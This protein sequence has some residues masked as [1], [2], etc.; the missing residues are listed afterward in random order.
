MDFI[1]E[2]SRGFNEKSNMLVGICVTRIIM[3]PK[4]L[5]R[6]LIPR[7]SW[8]GFIWG[9]LRQRR[10]LLSRQRL[11][12]LLLLWLKL[13]TLSGA[14]CRDFHSTEEAILVAVLTHSLLVFAKPFVVHLDSRSCPKVQL[15]AQHCPGALLNY[16]VKGSF[17]QGFLQRNV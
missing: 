4:N 10:V 5:F 15:P 13:D 11:N 2:P 8:R 1:C 7:M 12:L 17:L 6:H 9:K 16:P 3:I 14:L